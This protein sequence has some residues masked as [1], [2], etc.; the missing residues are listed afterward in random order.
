MID[1]H[2]DKDATYIYVRLNE[3][4]RNRARTVFY[5]MLS[6][7][8]FWCMVKLLYAFPDRSIVED[9]ETIMREYPVKE[10]QRIKDSE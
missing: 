1:I 5:L 4:N 8:L 10:W 9:P 7:F 6:G 2:T 3:R